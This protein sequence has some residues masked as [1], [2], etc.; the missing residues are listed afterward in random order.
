MPAWGR[1]RAGGGGCQAACISGAGPAGH[2]VDSHK[3]HLTDK[4][5][6]GIGS[7]AVA[8]CEARC[9]AALPSKCTGIRWHASDAHCHLL[10][11]D[12]PEGDAFEEALKRDD[13]HT[14]CMLLRKTR[15]AA[16]VEE[17]A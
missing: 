17:Q 7:K 11:G 12:T 5:L 1:R 9:V 8:A 10:S 4:D 13:A 14:A 6:G 3:L 16:M 15:G 2:D